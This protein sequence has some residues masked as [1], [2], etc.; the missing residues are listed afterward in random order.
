MKA[1]AILT[2]ETAHFSETDRDTLERMKA[3]AVDLWSHFPTAPERAMAEKLASLHDTPRWVGELAARA[4]KAHMIWAVQLLHNGVWCRY[5][6][7]PPNLMT[8]HAQMARDMAASLGRTAG[9]SYVR[10]VAAPRIDQ[11]PVAPTLAASRANAADLL[12]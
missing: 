2:R 10:I 4:A 3:D 1:Q 6:T 11:A 5:C 7:Y 9:T 8:D 12:A